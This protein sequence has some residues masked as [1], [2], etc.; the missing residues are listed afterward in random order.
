MKKL[1]KA[2]LW[3]KEPA[4]NPFAVCTSQQ[5]VEFLNQEARAEEEVRRRERF[6]GALGG[7]MLRR[8]I[9]CSCLL[10]NGRLFLKHPV[11]LAGKTLIPLLP[12]PEK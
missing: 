1:W 11:R 8:G 10:E 4:N 9:D 5:L 3:G 6:I 12:P 7:E 2:P